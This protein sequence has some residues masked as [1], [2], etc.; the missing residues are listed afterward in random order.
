[1]MMI[2]M[3]RLQYSVSEAPSETTDKYSVTLTTFLFHLSF[4]QVVKLSQVR[5]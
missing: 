1:M 2:Q 5:T 4:L 3:A